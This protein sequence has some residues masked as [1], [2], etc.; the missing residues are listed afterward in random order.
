MRRAPE[1]TGRSAADADRDIP[2]LLRADR[3]ARSVRLS[4]ARCGREP[5]LTARATAPAPDAGPC[6]RS[7]RLARLR[8]AVVAESSAYR[9]TSPATA[10]RS[11][12]ARVAVVPPAFARPDGATT[13][14][15]AAR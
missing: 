12:S 8:V 14:R 3:S 7:S 9:P 1:R 10:L 13:R 5:A 4:R 15:T 6:G 2:A 11:A